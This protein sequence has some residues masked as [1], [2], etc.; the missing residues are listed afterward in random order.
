MGQSTDDDTDGGRVGIGS[1]YTHPELA[2]L[3]IEGQLAPYLRGTDV[4][5]PQGEAMCP[6]CGTRYRLKPGQSAK[7]SH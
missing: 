1:A 3:I 6:Y 4:T 7:G 2:R 5:D